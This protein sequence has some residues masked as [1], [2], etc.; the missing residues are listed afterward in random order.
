MLFYQFKNIE[1]IHQIIHDSYYMKHYMVHCVRVCVCVLDG[2][3]W[4]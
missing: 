1:N 4:C 3:R 2:V